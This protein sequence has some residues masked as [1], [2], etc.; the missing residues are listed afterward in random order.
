VPEVQEDSKLANGGFELHR[1]SCSMGTCVSPCC[2]KLNYENKK[3]SRVFLMGYNSM[4][5]FQN[6]FDS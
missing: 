6:I 1:L 2:D 3:K 5:T 4:M